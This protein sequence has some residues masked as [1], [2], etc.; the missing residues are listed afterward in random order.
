M[1]ISGDRIYDELRDAGWRALNAGRLEEARESFARGLARSEELGE[2]VRT[3]RARCNLAAVLVELERT[4]EVKQQLRGMLLKNR[5]PGTRFLAAYTLSRA[6]EVEHNTDKALFYARIANRHAHEVGQDDALS[7][8]HNRLGSLLVATSDFAA[9]EP[10]L[11]QALALTPERPLGV[12][13]AAAL[14][15]LGYCCVV[16]GRVREGF[17]ALFESVRICRRL[18]ARRLEMHPRISLA[19][20]YLQLDRFDA[21][22]RH[23]ASGL[24]LAEEFEQ[25]AQIKY[26]LFILAEAEKL[27][28]NPLAARHH[29]LRLQEDY[30]PDSPQV[31]DLLLFLDVQS[32]INIK[33]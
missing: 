13:R 33:A 17:R 9:A 31:S 7:S 12:R 30:Y 21:A 6:Y 18:G 24:A 20:A 15:N 25:R 4:D 19:Y 1:S 5:D 22:Q 23:A 14:D 10:E 3:D 26:A 8:S 32:L 2:P 16:T 28:G 11:R 29:Y 27:S